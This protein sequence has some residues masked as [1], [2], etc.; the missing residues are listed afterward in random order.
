MLPTIE[1]VA[2]RAQVSTAT[3]S[4]CLNTPNRVAESTRDKV[5]AAVTELGYSPNFGAKALASKR[6]NTYGAIIPTMANAIFAKGLQTFQETL[7]E[8]GATLLVSSSYYNNAIEEEQIR[9]MVARGADGLLLIGQSRSDTIYQFLE[10]QNIPVVLAWSFDASSK[11]NMVGFDNRAAS[12][13]LAQKAIALGHRQFAFL[14]GERENNDRASER[15]KGAQQALAAAD[16][17]PNSM[18]VI[19]APYSIT[20]AGEAFEQLMSSPVKPSIVMC[21]NDVQAVGVLKKARERGIDVPGDVSITGFD[22][23]E[24]ASVVEPGITTVHVPHRQ[25]G[26]KSAE[27]L[28]SDD[29]KAKP[30]QTELQTYLVERDSLAAV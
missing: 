15:V 1:D 16:I 28:L 17:D 2:K 5:I 25:M 23:L 24:I 18:P 14:S 30:S 11:Y 10:Q 19:E 13:K 12:L 6:T 26:R 20:E 3:V 22:N 27:L 4:R 8:H 21:G 7:T 29:A 9:S